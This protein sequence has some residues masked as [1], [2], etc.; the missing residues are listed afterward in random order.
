M[1]HGFK[2]FST[3]LR[4]KAKIYDEMGMLWSWKNQRVSWDVKEAFGYLNGSIKNPVVYTTIT[5]SPTSILWLKFLSNTKE[6]NRIP[7]TR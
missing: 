2:R 6:F 5:T 7:S 4:V 3:P 1:L